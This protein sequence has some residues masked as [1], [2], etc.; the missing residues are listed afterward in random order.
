MKGPYYFR[1]NYSSTNMHIPY[2]RVENKMWYRT[3][4]GQ[5][6][7]TPLPYDHS[8]SEAKSG[9]LFVLGYFP[10]QFGT[11]APVN[12]VAQAHTALNGMASTDFAWLYNKAVA[13]WHD[14]A[15][16]RIQFGV[17]YAERKQLFDTLLPL[18]RAVR[19]PLR[20]LG[21][22]MSRYGGKGGIKR[23]L[24][25]VPRGWLA[26]HFGVEPLQR[27]IY[28]L[29]ER[30]LEN[31]K[32]GELVSAQA[33]T[34]RYAGRTSNAGDGSQIYQRHARIALRIAGVIKEDPGYEA[35]VQLDRYGLVNPAS[36][37]WELVPFSFVVDW[38][39]PIGQW[40]DT[41]FGIPGYSFSNGYRSL[42]A[43]MSSQEGVAYTDKYMLGTGENPTVQ[44]NSRWTGRVLLST[45]PTTVRQSHLNP[46]SESQVRLKTALSLLA[47]LYPSA[48]KVIIPP[49]MRKYK[50]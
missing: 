26:Y 24:G 45:W 27:E 23:A 2:L 28:E 44:V 38:F 1:E 36:I 12:L 42:H 3:N 8:V 29:L 46:W 21:D 39:Y 7:R 49:S 5:K 6:I 11:H 14:K 10:F 13:K 47:Q 37:G 16:M 22:V 18:L 30:F 15:R 34:T 20:N 9:A 32:K 17:D 25:D 19:R 4:N 48:E 41:L 43:T 31:R 40:L 35:L 50:T 33:S